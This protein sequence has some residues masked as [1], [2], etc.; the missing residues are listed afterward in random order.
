MLC[1]W[2]AI[3]RVAISGAVVGPRRRVDGLDESDQTLIDEV[4]R[5]D[6]PKEWL[7]GECRTR[8]SGCKR[9]V[10]LLCRVVANAA[11]VEASRAKCAEVAA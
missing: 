8:R 5:N 11:A 4:R 9:I 1:I 6:I 10:D 7:P 2:V 3:E